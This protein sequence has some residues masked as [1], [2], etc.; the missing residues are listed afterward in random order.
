MVFTHRNSG[1]YHPIRLQLC[2][3]AAKD[4]VQNF[5]FCFW[6]HLLACPGTHSNHTVSRIFKESM[7]LILGIAM[8]NAILCTKY[9]VIRYIRE[10]P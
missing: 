1:Q 6:W 9:W 3:F 8:D 10:K 2:G 7:D 4:I 5:A